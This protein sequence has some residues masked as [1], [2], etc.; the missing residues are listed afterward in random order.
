M[1]AL[2]SGG[3][4]ARKG[5]QTGGKAA[6][7]GRFA[8]SGDPRRA[9]HRRHFLGQGLVPESG[10]IPRL[11]EPDSARPRLRAQRFSPRPE[12]RRRPCGRPGQRHPPLFSDRRDPPSEG[13][14][15]EG[16]Q[17]SLYG[18]N[19]IPLGTASGKAVSGGHGDRHPPADRTLPRARRDILPLF[20]PGLG[21]HVQARRRGFLRHRRPPRSG[22]G[23]ALPLARRGP[24]GADRRARCGGSCGLA[25]D[26][27]QDDRGGGSGRD[28]RHRDRRGTDGG[29]AGHTDYTQTGQERENP[30]RIN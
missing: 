15:L 19:R 9:D 14:G 20:L 12:N 6:K 27:G 2:C 26:G 16:G 30:R 8:F 5:P 29:P 4:A 22:T 13:A 1:A 10:T 17:K 23:S 21:I 7:E 25:W 28:L 18:E 24:S 11:R 3:G